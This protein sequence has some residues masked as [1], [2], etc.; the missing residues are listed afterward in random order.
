[1]TARLTKPLFGLDRGA[2]IPLAAH[3]AIRSQFALR[4]LSRYTAK[5]PSA[6]E[7]HELQAAGI[8][9]AV[10]FEDGAQNALRGFDQGRADAEFAL[11][12]ARSLG[13]PAGRPIYFAVDFDATPNPTSTDRYF[14]GAASVLGH[15]G[16]GPYGGIAVVTH[17]LNRGFQWAW[18]T[19]AWSGRQL[20]ARAQ[21]YQYRNG[22]HIGL[23][24]Q[25]VEVDLN[26]AFY[27]D[28]GQWWGVA[29]PVP[30][31]PHGYLRFEERPLPWQGRL[32]H[33]RWLVKQYDHYRQAPNK[34]ANS[35]MLDLLRED[36]TR[37]RKRVWY[38][39]HVD[40]RTGKRNDKPTWALYH[41]GWRWQQLLQ[42]SRGDKVV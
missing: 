1:M 42:R 19:Y 4:Y 23:G 28:Y 41:R 32:L 26:Y 37:A 7:I 18:Q 15:Q 22:W 30:E 21:L 40:A 38:E 9:L 31:D 6:Q 20:D 27:P 33:E 24:G 10:V 17:Q 14:D 2:Y 39:A 34:G 8:G 16:C 11:G 36:L 3:H 35:E 13:M 5:V 12:Q 29:P 25:T